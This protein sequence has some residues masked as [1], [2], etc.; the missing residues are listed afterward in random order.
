MAEG[1]GIIMPKVGPLEAMCKSR[2]IMNVVLSESID[3]ILFKVV[4]DVNNRYFSG[5]YTILFIFLDLCECVHS[6]FV[7]VKFVLIMFLQLY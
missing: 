2:P 7:Q 4:K 3:D 6:I 5:Y 1:N